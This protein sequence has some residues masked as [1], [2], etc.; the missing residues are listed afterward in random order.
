MSELADGAQETTYLEQRLVS[1][2]V[3]V[4]TPFQLAATSK[5]PLRG[6]YECLAGVGVEHWRLD[7]SCGY[8]SAVGSAQQILC[9][10]CTGLVQ[11]R[12]ET[13]MDDLSGL[14]FLTIRE[15]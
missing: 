13:R 3:G 12:E 8:P 7:N 15:V 6:H 11:S 4:H 9:M 14:T 1:R 2:A 5:D 10:F